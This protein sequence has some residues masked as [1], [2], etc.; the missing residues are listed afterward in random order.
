GYTRTPRSEGLAHDAVTVT[1]PVPFSN[2]N[3]TFHLGSVTWFV[4]PNG[5]GKTK[6][7]D[8]I[9]SALGGFAACRFL[10]ADRL[11]G[12]E[13]H[14]SGYFTSGHFQQGFNKNQFEPLKS[15]AQQHGYG[16]D[17]ILLLEEDRSLR[18]LV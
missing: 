10:R 9:Q 11:T 4:G 16:A 12:L 2:Q 5:S 1:L 6:A 17:A 15:E 18:A 13:P 7:A 8:A 3:Y 14:R